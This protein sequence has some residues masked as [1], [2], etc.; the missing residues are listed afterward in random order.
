MRKIVADWFFIIIAFFFAVATPLQPAM[1][2]VTAYVLFD[3]EKPETADGLSISLMNCKQLIETRLPGPVIA[4]IT[5]N[6]MTDL[7][8]AVMMLSEVDGVTRA[9]IWMIEPGDDD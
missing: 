7:S 9:V 5:C 1:A 3:T 6:D 8:K 4:Q 2:L